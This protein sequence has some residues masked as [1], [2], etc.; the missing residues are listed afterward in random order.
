MVAHAHA[1]YQSMM[2]RSVAVLVFQQ[3]SRDSVLSCRLFR[4]VVRQLPSPSFRH[5]RVQ[6]CLTRA[7]PALGRTASRTRR[8]LPHSRAGRVELAKAGGTG[9]RTPAGVR[10]MREGKPAVMRNRSVKHHRSPRPG[11]ERGRAGKDTTAKS[12]PMQPDG[13]ETT[14]GGKRGGT[15]TQSPRSRRLPRLA[16]HA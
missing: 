13:K 8:L 3:K 5:C 1:V 12:G 15:A 6:S 10:G 9:S 7:L 4:A 2:H 11:P 16:N 14:T